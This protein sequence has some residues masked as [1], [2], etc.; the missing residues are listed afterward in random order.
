MK[1]QNFDFPISRYI[2]LTGAGFTYNYGGFLANRMWSE[3]HNRYLKLAENLEANKLKSAVK[4][5][6]NYEDLYE[7]VL[8]SSDFTKDEKELFFKAVLGAY[9]ALD[10]VIREFRQ[11]FFTSDILDLNKLREFFGKITGN[12]KERGFFFTLNQ[13]LFIERYC[14]A[15]AIGPSLPGLRIN[16]QRFK[17][18]ESN[19]LKESDYVKIVKDDNPEYRINEWKNTSKLFYIKLHGSYDWRDDNNQEILIIGTN[20]PSRISSSP[21]L[22]WYFNLFN[23]VLSIPKT[24]LMVIGYGFKDKHINEAIAQA[25]KQSSLKI[26]ILNPQDPEIFSKKTLGI[27]N[28]VSEAIWRAVEGYYQLTPKE[29]FSRNSTNASLIRNLYDSYFS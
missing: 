6:F 2:L 21:I 4:K 28:W 25:V 14:Y 16:N 20:K 26:Y 5:T 7:D 22:A 27:N 24:K 15:G 19:P 23:T 10:D 29:I 11:Q 12:P 1:I 17:S 13:D 9:D 3:I 8:R 18:R